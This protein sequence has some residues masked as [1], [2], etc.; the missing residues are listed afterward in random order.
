MTGSIRVAVIGGGIVGTAT[1]AFLAG[2]GADVRLYERTAIAA[3]AS[4]RNSGIIQHPIDPLLAELYRDSLDRYRELVTA[5][6]R[7][8]TMPAEPVG[9]LYIGGESAPVEELASAWRQAW[10]GTRPSVLRGEELRRLE[11]ALATRLAACRLEIGYPVAPA[12]ATTAY[13]ELARRLGAEIV[14]GDAQPAIEGDTAVGVNVDGGLDRA[15]VVV[16]AAGPW[17]PRLVDPTGRWRP[18]RPIWGVV[19]EVGLTGAPRHGLEAVE[20]AAETDDDTGVVEEG[21]TAGSD[22]AAFSLVTADGRSSLGSTFLDTEPS[23]E[24]WIERLRRAGSRFVPDIATAPLLGTRACARPV[25]LDGR[26]LIGPLPGINRLVV[27]AGNGPWGIS[28]GPGTARLAADLVLAR[29]APD[30]V[31]AGLR[32]S[33]LA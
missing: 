20:I 27:A 4:G 31:P 23:A 1:A 17:T 3:G 21:A 11:P 18:I 5:S 12:A 15:D 28:T 9:L 2:A 32:A 13:A 33:R 24:A 25:S 6:D 26:P 30:D 7:A 10:P 14:L 8:F 22:A 29:I 19:A 16:V